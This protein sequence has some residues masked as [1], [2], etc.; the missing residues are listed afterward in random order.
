MR[1]YSVYLNISFLYYKKNV[2]GAT[3]PE[4]T[5]NIIA[6]DDGLGLYLPKIRA[7]AIADLHIGIELALFGE[8]TY[9]PVDQYQI[10]QN[11]IVKLIEKYN[12]N[13]LIINGDFKHEFARAS[14]QEW[15][16]LRALLQTLTD[17]GVELEIVRGNHDNYLKTI[18]SHEGKT[19][20]EPYFVKSE[21][22]F[23]HGHQS[24]DEVFDNAIPDVDWIILAHEHPAIELRD[25][26]GGK[27]KFR[28]YLRGSWEA[29]NFIVMPSYSPLASGAVMNKLDQTRI[30]SPVLREI[31]LGDFKPVV[32]D[33][34]ELLTFPELR[35]LNKLDKYDVKKR[36][37]TTG[38]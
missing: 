3:M 26:T 14:Q 25:D 12:P 20:R 1:I 23:L 29:Y 27:H 34:G 5:S 21:Y 10:M 36:T 28:C 8:G 13:L 15:F 2:M 18:L 6:T 37:C 4:L 17:I 7:L 11:N 32:V 9:I 31:N 24:F 33:K 22:L 38:Q 16:E 30:L 35:Q 19:I